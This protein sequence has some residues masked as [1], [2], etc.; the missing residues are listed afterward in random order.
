MELKFIEAG[1]S[2]PG[3]WGKFAVGRYTD[4]E[5]IEPTRFP[6]CEGQRVVSLRGNGVHHIWVFDLATGEAA[7]F[8]PGGHAKADL[9]SHKIWVCPLFEPFL[10]WLYQH[11][12]EK[13]QVGWWDELPRSVVMPN[14][15][16]FDLAGYRRSGPDSRECADLPG[17][18]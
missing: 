8:T 13:G 12:A 5:L 6:G 9:D 2:T 15:T 7:R 14:N 17:G 1:H 18:L 3:N 16:P 4:A 11:I 10:V